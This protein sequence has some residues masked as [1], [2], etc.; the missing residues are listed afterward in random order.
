MDQILEAEWDTWKWNFHQL[1]LKIPQEVQSPSQISILILFSILP[2]LK[3]IKI[4]FD[5]LKNVII[6][7]DELAFDSL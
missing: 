4:I 6:L 1:E 3:S 2:I 5:D 7:T